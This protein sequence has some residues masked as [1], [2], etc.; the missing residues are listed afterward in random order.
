[1]R[2]P[3]PS[4]RLHEYVGQFILFLWEVLVMR[5]CPFCKSEYVSFSY[6]KHPYGHDLVFVS[7][8]RCGA[9]GP[10]AVYP[11]Q[12]YAAEAHFAEQTA[13]ELWDERHNVELRGAERDGEAGMR[14]VPLERRVGGESQSPQHGEK[15]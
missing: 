3:K 14:S 8:S 12:E 2:Q 11:P 1:M 13:E 15:G 4:H 9:A 6:T 5:P 7:C 10:V